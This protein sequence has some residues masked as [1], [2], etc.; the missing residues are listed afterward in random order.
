MASTAVFGM[1]FREMGVLP[2]ATTIHAIPA[3]LWV[4]E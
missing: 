1:T 3:T 4:F 2:P